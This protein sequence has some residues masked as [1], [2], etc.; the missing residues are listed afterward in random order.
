MSTQKNMDVMEDG[1]TQAWY[2]EIENY[3]FEDVTYKNDGMTS[4][5]TQVVWKSVTKVGFGY[6]VG[7]NG[8]Y[9]CARYNPAGNVNGKSF[10]KENVPPPLDKRSLQKKSNELNPSDNNSLEGSP[11]S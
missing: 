11:K 5:F 8:T 10:Y 9:V 2:D 7:E 1:A 4:H 3:N 6:A